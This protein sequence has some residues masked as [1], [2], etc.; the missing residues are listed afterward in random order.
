MDSR[1]AEIVF[2]TDRAAALNHELATDEGCFCSGKEVKRATERLESNG[3]LPLC[4]S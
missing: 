1:V 4:L 2:A 3:D